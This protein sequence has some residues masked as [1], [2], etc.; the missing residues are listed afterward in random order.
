MSDTR[1]HGERTV[2]LAL[3]G[4]VLFSVPVLNSFGADEDN[5]LFGI[6]SLYL[7]LFAA[8]ALLIGL[9]A[10]VLEASPAANEHPP[11]P[12]A[13]RDRDEPDRI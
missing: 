4:A 12:R 7:Y 8:W 11:T 9:L 6:P 1:R 3:L 2:A 5:L 13:G 10:L